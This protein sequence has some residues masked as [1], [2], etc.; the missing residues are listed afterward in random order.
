LIENSNGH[1][2]KRRRLGVQAAVFAR[3]TCHPGNYE[4]VVRLG[5]VGVCLG[6]V[7]AWATPSPPW[8]TPNLGFAR[9]S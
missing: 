7:G 8:A 6:E 5:E 4:H 3:R 1:G 2:L 9:L